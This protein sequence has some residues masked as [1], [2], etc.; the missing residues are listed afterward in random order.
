MNLR[1]LEY[2][3]AVA[4]HRHFGK[5]AEACHVSQPA[6]SM[7]IKKL[8]DEFRVQLFERTNKQVFP[9]AVGREIIDRARRVIDE[10]RGIADLA[11]AHQD[12]LAGN[13]RLGAFPTLSPYL[14]PEIVPRIR[15]A[16]PDLKLFLIEEKT[17]QLLAG[18]KDGRIDAAF[19][20]LPVEEDG[21]EARPLFEDRFA[22]AV[23][24]GHSLENRKCVSLSDIA[25]EP[26]LLLEE[27]HCLRAQALDVCGMMGA[28]EHSDFRA[29][30]LETL[31]QMV[32]ANMGVTLIPEIAAIPGGPIRYIPFRAP[33]PSRIIALVS[34]K[35]TTRG[36]CLAKLSALVMESRR[37]CGPPPGGL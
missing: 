8:E 36:E 2:L 31:R 17:A 11:R 3:V 4:D 20:A 26:L 5:A 10:A 30:S 15:L 6:L 24:A 35:S 22:L 27:G 34:R 13:L 9:T 7:Q 1:D 32:A 33:C 23:P 12:P 19:I 25:G 28:S 21:L 16:M 37:N 29:T 14:F 18:L